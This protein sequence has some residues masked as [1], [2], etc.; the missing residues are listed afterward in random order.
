MLYYVNENRDSQKEVHKDAPKIT[1]PYVESGKSN[2][3]YEYD[4]AANYIIKGYEEGPRVSYAAE[5]IKKFP[6]MGR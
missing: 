3:F 4:P 5:L 1:A 6:L 2:R